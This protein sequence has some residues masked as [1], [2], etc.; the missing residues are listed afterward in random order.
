[1]LAS[2]CTGI[3]PGHSGDISAVSMR[4]RTVSAGSVLVASWAL[5][6]VAAAGP[7]DGAVPATQP[8]S[9]GEETGAQQEA[10]GQ[11][12]PFPLEVELLELQLGVEGSYDR[13]SVSSD[14]PGGLR[15]GYKQIDRAWRLRETLGMHTAGSLISPNVLLFDVAVD[16]GWDQE[17]YSESTRYGKRRMSPTGSPFNYDLALN[18]LPRGKI[19]GNVYAQHL[20]SRLPRAFLPSLDRTRERYAVELLYN[21][22]KLPMRLE[23][24]HIWDELTSRT[25][26]LNDDEQRG[27][28]ALRYEATWQISRNH[29]LRL[30]YEYSDRLEEYSGSRTRFDTIRNYLALNHTLR[31][32]EKDR[33]YWQT[34]AR[35]QDET[36]ELGRDIAELNSRLQIQLNDALAGRVGGQ[37]LR[38]AFQELETEVWRGEVGVTHQLGNVLTTDL[39]LYGLQQQADKNA[40][41]SE[42]GGLMN[43]SFNQD[44]AWG[45]LSANVSYNHVGTGTRNGN[46]G[47]IVIG[48]SVTFRDPLP[49]FL[50]HPDVKPTSIV[51]TDA[52]SSRTYLPGRDYQVIRSGRYTALSRVPTGQIADRETVL[53]SYLYEVF[54]DYDIRRDRVD[55]RVQQAF[56][57]G[58]APYYAGSIQDEDLND[59]R[60]VRFYGRNVNRH[61]VGATY[62]QTGWA[63]GLEYEYNDDSIDPYQALHANGDVV[64]YHDPRQELNGK[65]MMSQFWFDGAEELPPRD[66]L[67]LDLGLNYRM[68]LARDLEASASASYRFEDDSLFGNTHGVDLLAA[69]EWDIGYLSLRFEAEYDVLDL[70]D[71]RDNAASF[72]IKIKRDIPVL[73]SHER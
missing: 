54:R 2:L 22:A 39:E 59:A 4:R 65:G 69:L 7:P 17:W 53:V 56:D 20:D 64:L 34:L 3:L 5:C 62:R 35:F 61:R 48:E 43:A 1:M 49:A 24:E 58:L 45:R 6:A 66:T 55:F 33:S 63:A 51:V 72:W 73:A 52:R 29:A 25:R 23:Y 47:G 31:F 14:Y 8:A 30:E 15:Q 10:A 9:S 36:G 46:R 12:R 57:F 42:W 19:S 13:R 28:D 38:N 16:G 60:F 50:V 41:F 11:G 18:L 27:R 70:P 26:Y 71:S 37:Y 32:G 68:F 67:L 44:N 40:D 21:D